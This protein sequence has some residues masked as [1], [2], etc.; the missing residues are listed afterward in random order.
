[1]EHTRKN[2]SLVKMGH[3]LK[4]GSITLKRLGRPWENGPHL[5]NWVTLGKMGLTRKHGSHLEKMSHTFKIGLHL[6]K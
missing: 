1:M 3:F 4:N 6:K 5:E 2:G